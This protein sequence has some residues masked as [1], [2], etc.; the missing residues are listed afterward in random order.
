LRLSRPLGITKAAE[1][2]LV[3]EIALVLEVLMDS[4][5]RSVVA[6]NRG[7]SPP[8]LIGQVIFRHVSL[9]SIRKPRPKLGTSL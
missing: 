7:A 6:V 1:I 5:R 2:A 3:T 8:E 4:D 9:F